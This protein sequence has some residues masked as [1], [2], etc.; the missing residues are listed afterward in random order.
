[1][2][3]GILFILRG[4]NLGIPFLSPKEEMIKKKVEKTI[5]V[6]ESRAMIPMQHDKLEPL[7]DE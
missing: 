5:E 1:M 7:P 4:L 2:I 3:I 6:K